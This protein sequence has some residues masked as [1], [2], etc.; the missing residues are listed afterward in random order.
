M[1]GCQRGV[2]CAHVA[3]CMCVYAHC[4][5]TILLTKDPVLFQDCDDSNHLLM[6]IY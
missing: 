3:A 5:S 2:T 4:W 1:L 6:D